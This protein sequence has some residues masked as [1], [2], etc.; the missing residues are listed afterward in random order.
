MRGPR[1]QTAD[2]EAERA[3]LAA[4]TCDDGAY[5]LEI[6]EHDVAVIAACRVERRA[7]DADRAGPVAAR[8]A[9]EE[10]ASGVEPCVPRQRIEVVLRTHDVGLSERGVHR[11]QSGLVI[12]HV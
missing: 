11:L 10:R 3:S 8:H 1:R 9:I 12:P 2:V 5:E 4:A 7:P 6:L